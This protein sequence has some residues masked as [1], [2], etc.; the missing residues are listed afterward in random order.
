MPWICR[1]V[2]RLVVWFRLLAA[3]CLSQGLHSGNC[4]GWPRGPKKAALGQATSEPIRVYQ[5]QSQNRKSSLETTKRS[6]V[7][8]P[9][10]QTRSKPTIRARAVQGGLIPKARKAFALFVQERNSVRKGAAKDEFAA[11]MKQMGEIWRAMAPEEKEPSEKRS[12]QEFKAQH[13]AMMR[14]GFHA[15]QELPASHV[16]SQMPWDQEQPLLADGF[17][18]PSQT[19]K[20]QIGPHTVLWIYVGIS[21]HIAALFELHLPCHSLKLKQYLPRWWMLLDLVVVLMAKCLLLH[22]LMA[23]WAAIKLFRK[24]MPWMMLGEKYPCVKSWPSCRHPVK[25]GMQ[26]CC[27]MTCVGSCF[28]GLLLAMRAQASAMSW[29]PMVHWLRM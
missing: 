16:Q 15:R 18:N 23:A 20:L 14:L 13:A 12:L 9:K 25:D 28:H 3:V 10:S 26:R 19:T 6:K 4:H 2:G 11:E 29:G 8:G 27:T 21:C 7:Q 5:L 24:G 22:A 17:S 1:H